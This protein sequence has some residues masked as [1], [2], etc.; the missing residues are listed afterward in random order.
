MTGNDEKEKL[1]FAKA[2]TKYEMLTSKLYVDPK[3]VE[4]EDDDEE[5]NR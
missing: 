1:K 2:W 3:K 5:E 4:Y